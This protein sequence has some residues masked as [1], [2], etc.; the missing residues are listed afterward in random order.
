MHSTHTWCSKLQYSCSLL[1][2]RYNMQAHCYV[3][4]SRCA[5]YFSGNPHWVYWCSCDQR[6]SE[7]LDSLSST[8]DTSFQEV[9]AMFP[10]CLHITTDIVKVGNEGSVCV[11]VGDN[12]GVVIC[13]QDFDITCATCRYGKSNCTHVQHVISTITNDPDDIPE[14]LFRL[15]SCMKHEQRKNPAATPPTLQSWKKISFSVPQH[16]AAIMHQPIK[17][18]FHVDNGVCHLTDATVITQNSILPAKGMNVLH[19]FAMLSFSE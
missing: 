5:K 11:R 16:L 4:V 19:V 12:F 6:R 8:S 13:G 17:E 14:S 3:F 9:S 2:C 7:F 10:E 15:A 1:A 18:R